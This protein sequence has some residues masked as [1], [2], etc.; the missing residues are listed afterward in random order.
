MCSGLSPLS[1]P[2]GENCPSRSGE[3][4]L[5]VFVVDFDGDDMI[6][7]EDLAQV[8]S[9]LT[10]QQRLSDGDMEQLIKNVSSQR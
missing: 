7:K 2:P 5:T 4:N 1:P 10:G 3:K 9:R 6:S 8:I